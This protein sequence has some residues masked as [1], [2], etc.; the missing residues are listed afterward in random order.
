MNGNRNSL[1]E[2]IQDLVYSERMK[3]RITQKQLSEQTGISQANISRIENGQAL[4]QLE[5]L[6]KIADCVGKRLVVS[7]VDSEEKEL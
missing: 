4:P 7:F 6:K 1:N 5:S 2:E 3:A